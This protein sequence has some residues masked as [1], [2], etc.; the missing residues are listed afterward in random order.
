MWIFPQTPASLHQ[1]KPNMD[2]HQLLALGALPLILSGVWMHWR[3]SW[4]CSDAEE[5]VKDRKLTPE[6]ARRRIALLNWGCFALTI[7]GLVLLL[8]GLDRMGIF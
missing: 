7:L 2:K 1:P 6:Q 4:Y 5:A 8:V 3:L